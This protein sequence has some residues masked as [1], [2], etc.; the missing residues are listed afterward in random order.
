MKYDIWDKINLANILHNCSHSDISP[1]D[2]GRV[3]EYLKD[4]TPF[5]PLSALTKD[6]KD[7]QR[8]WAIRAVLNKV[9]RGG[10]V[11]EI[12][13]GNPYVSETLRRLG[14][15]MTIVDPYEGHGGGPT[16]FDK[17]KSNFPKINFI[18]TFFS[19]GC[20]N[21]ITDGSFDAIIS[22]SVLEHI[23]PENLSEIGLGIRQYLRQGGVSIHAVDFP[24]LGPGFER[25]CN[26][27]D[28]INEEIVFQKIDSKTFALSMR[29]ELDLMMMPSYVFVQNHTNAKS[30]NKPVWQRWVS[31]NLVGEMS[32]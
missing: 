8:C 17:L 3:S 23:T 1:N 21:E 26:H 9:P 19:S 32:L 7:E 29:E 31:I 12:G 5:Y 2:I 13:A 6:L 10:R 11:L 16:N 15:D 20:T 4:F 27:L 22:V 24:I 28:V 14:Y 25:R 30:H 18:R